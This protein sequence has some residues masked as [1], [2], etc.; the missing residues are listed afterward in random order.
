MFIE[1]NKMFF[2]GSKKVLETELHTDTRKIVADILE[3]AFKD[4]IKDYELELDFSTVLF[5]SSNVTTPTVLEIPEEFFEEF[6]SLPNITFPVKITTCPPTEVFNTDRMYNVSTLIFGFLNNIHPSIYDRV[7]KY[8]GLSVY[9]FGDIQVEA[10]EFNNYHINIL[11]NALYSHKLDPDLFRLVD[12]KKINT[13]LHKLRKDTII[14][15]SELSNS[16]LVYVNYDLNIDLSY[17]LNY[18]QTHENSICVVP[19]GVLSRINS[20]LWTQTF[21]NSKIELKPNMEF[22]LKYPYTHITKDDK[23]VYIPALAKVN[24]VFEPDSNYRVILENGHRL[25][26]VK[27]YFEYNSIRYMPDTNI[28]VDIDDLILSFDPSLQAENY[29][30]YIRL[31][32]FQADL[33]E[34]YTPTQLK[35]LEVTDHFI[36]YLTPFLIVTPE[37]VKYQNFNHILGY[38]ELEERDLTFS[39]DSYY[40][41]FCRVLDSI[42]IHYAEIYNE[43]NVF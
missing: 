41:Q 35:N 26:S 43:S 25:V 37:V 8:A 11:S 13:T 33:E 32:D 20:V 24:I 3:L 39:Y 27:A 42:E 15:L 21:G 34:K 6:Q 40:K 17:I 5:L 29:Y 19:R 30:D 28:L 36:A 1:N 38:L 16:S 14:N 7:I 2:I 4:E 9:I 31:L 18:L 12:K 23:Y 10:N 22:Y